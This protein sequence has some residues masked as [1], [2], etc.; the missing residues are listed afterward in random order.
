M[1]TFKHVIPLE[2]STRKLKEMISFL[3]TSP[4]EIRNVSMMYWNGTITLSYDSTGCHKG[5]A[6]ALFQDCPPIQSLCLDPDNSQVS[7]NTIEYAVTMYNFSKNCLN[8]HI[9]LSL[10]GHRLFIHI[11]PLDKKSDLLLETLIDQ[12]TSF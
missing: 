1:K 11:T 12:P 9:K 5:L 8:C 10:K 3:G 7:H 4:E 6:L 2:A